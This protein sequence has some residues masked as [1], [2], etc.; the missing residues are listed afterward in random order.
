MDVGQVKVRSEDFAST[1]TEFL[2]M[3]SRDEQTTY[4]MGVR[5]AFNCLRFLDKL[6]ITERDAFNLMDLVE[7]NDDCGDLELWSTILDYYRN[8]NSPGQNQI[9]EIAVAAARN[10]HSSAYD[11]WQNE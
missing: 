3:L 4:W 8:G 1:P 5:D 6:T 2:N 10:W 11:D 7:V 9:G